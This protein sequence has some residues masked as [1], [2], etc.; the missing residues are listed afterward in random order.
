MKSY[1]KKIPILQRTTSSPRHHFCLLTACG[2]GGIDVP[3]GEINE[4]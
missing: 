4:E 1:F 2:D 3:G